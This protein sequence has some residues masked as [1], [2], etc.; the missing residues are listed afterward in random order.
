[1]KDNYQDANGT[2]CGL[3]TESALPAQESHHRRRFNRAKRGSLI[4]DA[5]TCRITVVSRLVFLPAIFPGHEKHFSG[6]TSA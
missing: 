2:G 3:P 5:V 1:M 6:L 4:P